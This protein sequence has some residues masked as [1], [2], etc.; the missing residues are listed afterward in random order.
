[1]VNEVKMSNSKL[2]Y[3][4]LKSNYNAVISELQAVKQKASVEIHNLQSQLQQVSEYQALQE[5]NLLVKFIGMKD[6][7][8]PEFIKKCID[9]IESTILNPEKPVEDKK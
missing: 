3:E 1:M 5:L 8:H 9:R 6:S 7:F 4:Q 2:T